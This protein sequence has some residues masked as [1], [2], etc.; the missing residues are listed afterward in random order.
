[1]IDHLPP[2]FW[3]PVAV[4]LWLLLIAVTF[5]S[6]SQIPNPDELSRS[7]VLERVG[8]REFTKAGA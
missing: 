5:R 6:M 3:V 7:D 1:M 4:V 2:V 8:S